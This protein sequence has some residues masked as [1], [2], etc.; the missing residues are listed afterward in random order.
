MLVE[1]KNDPDIVEYGSRL[2]PPL[3]NSNKENLDEINFKQTSFSD[4]AEDEL[5][6]E[7][8]GD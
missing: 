1:E 8:Y 2:E 5:S 3:T 6:S 4:I 7:L